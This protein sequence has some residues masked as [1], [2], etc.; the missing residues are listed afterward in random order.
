M[1]S[2]EEV[3]ISNSSVKEEMSKQS[4]TLAS[5]EMEKEILMSKLNREEKANENMLLEIQSLNERLKDCEEEK[6]R[7]LEEATRSQVNS[8]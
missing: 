3:K 1:S 5:L 6:T 8:V 7:L 4:E 2:S